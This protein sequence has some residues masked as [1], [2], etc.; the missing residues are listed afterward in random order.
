MDSHA[1]DLV[2]DSVPTLFRQ[3]V[4]LHQNGHF[5]D[6]EQR[7][8][9]ILEASP[10]HDG[11]I[12][13]LGMLRFLYR[14]FA[15]ALRLVEHSLALRNN[16]PLYHN[17]HGVILIELRRYDDAKSA[18]EKAVA[19]DPNCYDA[20][21]NLGVVSLLLEQ[22]VSIAEQYF[23]TALRLCPGHLDSL[24]RLKDFYIK[25]DRFFESLELAEEIVCH[26]P[27]GFEIH[28]QL[29][30]L[31]GDCGEMKKSQQH[32]QKAGMLPGGKPAW[33]WKHLWYCPT[34]FENEEEIEQYWS[35]LNADLDAAV[36]EK[37][38]YDWRTIAY[39]AFTYP[40]N[41]Q[42]LNRCCRTTLEKY[43]KLFEASFPFERPTYQPGK[44]IRVGFLVT[45]SHE[46]G[47]LRM[48]A[49]T[50][51][52]LDPNRFEVILIFSETSSK[53]FQGRFQRSDLTMISYDGVFEKAVQTIKEAKC[54]VI[55][56]WKIGAD[57]WSF[58]L[59]MCR[60]APIQFTAWGTHGT[61][62]LHH[63]DYFLS[64]NKAELPE[65]QDHYTEQLFLFE[66]PLYYEPIPKELQEV[67][68]RKE[69][70][71]P[72]KD[73]IYLCPHRPPKYH[74]MFDYYLR[75]ILQKD[76][77]GHIVLFM[78]KSSHL[79]ERFIRRMRRTIGEKLFQR[80]IVLPQQSLTSYFR[81][82][83]IATAILQSPVYSGKITTLDGFLYGV[84][85]VAQ[86]GDLLIQR[87]ENAF[88]NELGIIGPSVSLKEEYV[89]QVVRLGT[90]SDYREHISKQIQ[91][92]KNVLFENNRSIR[93]WERFLL[94]ITNRR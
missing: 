43:T 86:K 9:K 28:H 93:E 2:N 14:D 60:L 39:D 11:A 52:Q 85:S 74:P 18:F 64:W 40:F 34:F 89:K 25:Q 81:Y 20:I 68:Q 47:F 26:I 78:G 42:H 90:D 8:R 50:I 48:N 31:Y 17:N 46:G 44:K 1:N 45:P 35:N 27:E 36:E 12:H 73:A 21:S 67:S 13:F 92:G 82:C 87:Y 62:G 30:C 23:R 3:A 71:L 76:P 72:E 77:C 57:L 75:E 84:P 37:P 4:E 63:V 29:G 55:Y 32:L 94:T 16:D 54:D 24:R 51:E 80:I 6:A 19:F 15:D 70:N 56:Y 53:R 38:F 69:L 22:P 91:D 61:G 88:Y 66:T 10:D 7:Y 33:K 79:A 83:S 65:A 5:S 59:P 49:N 58:F 41:L